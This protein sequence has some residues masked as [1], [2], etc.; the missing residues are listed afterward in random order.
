MP[1]DGEEAQEEE[2]GGNVV[3]YIAA[4]HTSELNHAVVLSK[5]GV[6]ETIEYGCKEGVEAI[7]EN[8]ALCPLHKYFP[9]NGLSRDEGVG[10]DIAEG[11][12]GGNE[13]D[14]A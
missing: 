5:D 7:G 1:D 10:G 6:G 12:Y 2:D 3:A 4:R 14:E 11:L 9:L 8:A 13:I